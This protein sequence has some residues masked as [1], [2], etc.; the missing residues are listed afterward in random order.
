MSFS[1]IAKVYDR[2]NDLEIY[3]KWLDFTLDHAPT[4]SSAMPLKVLADDAPHQLDS[5]PLIAYPIRVLDVACGTGWFTQL[6]A[7]FVN[8]VVGFDIDQEMLNIAIKELGES[9]NITYVQDDM[10]NITHIQKGFDLATCYADSFCF[11]SDFD[12]VERSF[13]EIYD[14]LNEGGML[15]FD[16]WT[17][18]QLTTGFDGFSYFDSDEMSALMW[19]SE[20]EQ[21]DMTVY[22]YLT[23]FEPSAGIDAVNEGEQPK[24]YQRHDVVLKERTYP[25]T[26]Y[27]TALKNIGFTSVDIYID[28]GAQRYNPNKHQQADRWFFKCVK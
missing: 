6:L 18:Y 1:Q 25:H 9:P 10:T 11:L 12:A 23:V 26:L 27:E 17:P 22:H 7:P 15:L 13:R 14:Q 19:D 5:A 3:E 28:Y 8:E 2:F 24:A 16:V 20:V 21:D 4:Q